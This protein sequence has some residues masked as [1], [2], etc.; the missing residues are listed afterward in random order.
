MIYL[1]VSYVWMGLGALGRPYPPLGVSACSGLTEGAEKAMVPPW[2]CV[3]RR[4]YCFVHPPPNIAF[5]NLGLRSWVSSGSRWSYVD[6]W[7]ANHSIWRESSDPG[8]QESLS[9]GSLSCPHSARPAGGVWIHVCPKK[10]LEQLWLNSHNEKPKRCSWLT[11]GGPSRCAR[12][13]HFLQA[14]QAA[15]ADW[16]SPFLTGCC[17]C[18]CGGWQAG[19][20]GHKSPPPAPRQ[21][22]SVVDDLE[23]LLM[24]MTSRAVRI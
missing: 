1:H 15:G 3:Q 6:A 5:P 17:A 7:A 20:R 10:D 2:V 8:L 16:Q 4:G 23:W 21:E 24:T 9:W 14:P 18:A 19:Q 12:H 11:A 13:V 22:D